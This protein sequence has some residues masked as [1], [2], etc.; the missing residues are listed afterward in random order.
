MNDLM[1]HVERIVRP[2]RARQSRKLRMRRELL[3]HLQAALEEDRAHAPDEPSALE[4]AT[5]RLGEP[6]E[7]T[8]ELQ[9]SVPLIERLLLA[10]T[11]MK[12]SRWE[13]HAGKVF[14]LYDPATVAHQ[15]I[16][17]GSGV[18]AV[19]IIWMFSPHIPPEARTRFFVDEFDHPGRAKTVITIVW[20]VQMIWFYF[21]MRFL[22]AAAAPAG[23]FHLLRVIGAG[24][25][26]LLAQGLLMFLIATQII[27]RSPTPAEM[28]QSLGIT[29]PLLGIGI[30]VGRGVAALRRPYDE[31]LTLDL[32]Q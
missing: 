2:V 26:V 14:G 13:K 3:A 25:L 11:P 18:L 22:T 4:Q 5:R 27:G 32:S 31:W 28:A 30:L 17:L 6:A 12:W 29:L 24:I 19:V 7:L 1:I 23:R 21:G 9:Q 10:R 8:R 20:A 16:L 15:L